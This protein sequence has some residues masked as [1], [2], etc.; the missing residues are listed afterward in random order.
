MKRFTQTDARALEIKGDHEYYL[1][2]TMRAE[3]NWLSYKMTPQR[4][5]TDTAEYN[6]RLA[7]A[8]KEGKWDFVEKN[9]TALVTKLVSMEVKILQRLA[10]G[11]FKCELPLNHAAISWCSPKSLPFA[12]EAGSETFWRKHCYAVP[13]LEKD[14]NSKAEKEKTTKEKSSKGKTSSENAQPLIKVCRDLV[15]CSGVVAEEVLHR[16][17]PEKRRYALVAAS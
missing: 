8:A 13:Q 9:P 1:F 5:A 14:A 12:A 10:T 11:N 3:R 4:W 6:T 2:M 16:P 15:V 17:S 7:A